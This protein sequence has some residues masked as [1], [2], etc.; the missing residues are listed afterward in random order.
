MAERDNGNP[1]YLIIGGTGGI[2][3]EVCRVLNERGAR[4][5]IAARGE[6]RLK[7]L[8]SEYD[9]HAITLEATDFDAVAG[10]V[11]EVVKKFGR[12]DGVVNAVGSIML[13]PAHLTSREEWDETV[14]L[15]LTSAFGVVRAAA[16]AM[17]SEGGSIVLISTAAARTGIHNHEAIAA[18]KAGVIGLTQASAA[19]Y[20]NR[21]VRVNCVAPG[22][23]KTP[24]SKH[25]TQNEAAEKAS[26]QMHPM[27]RLGEPRDVAPLIAYLLGDES[28]WV[29][30]QVF[31]VDGGL[32]TARP[33][34]T[35]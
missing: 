17:M 27:G 33:R 16:K 9:A 11:D 28:G 19:T 25:L 21:G 2:G 18:C 6:E 34:T 23:V 14:A 12:I 13:K 8:A 26:K 35:V 22:L 31:G 3:S 7:G 4:L 1:V 15:N 20:A 29:T 24:L 32:S 5:A 30:G 10:A